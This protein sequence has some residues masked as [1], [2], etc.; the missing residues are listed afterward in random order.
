MSFPVRPIAFVLTST[1][2]GTMIV[3]RNDYCELQQGQRFG[4]GH[5]LLRRSFYEA[6]EIGLALAMLSC[7]QL[8]R[9]D[10]VVALDGGANIGVH[11]VE[12]ARHM[13]G[14]GEV[15]SFEAQEAIFYALAGNLAINN[16]FNAHARLSAL[17]AACGNIMIPVPNYYAPA[18]FGS[19]ELRDGISSE[20]IGQN[21]SYKE[22]DCVSVPIVTIDSLGLKR[23]DFLKID[24]EGMEV[25][26]LEGA[27]AALAA[28]HPVIMAEVIKTDSAK[29]LEILKEFGYEVFN[30]GM[31]VLA[32]GA[33][34]PVL[35]HIEKTDTGIFV[36][37]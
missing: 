21:I 30:L 17:G 6:D 27:R 14:W 12:W 5:Q 33:D 37:L 22:E 29:M 4:V 11:S 10:G 13:F 23:L 2:H 20:F 26:V 8:H 3:N 28:Y 19:L 9:G 24:V 7:V 25:E 34:D 36:T 1:N 18:S 35:K 16:C 15:Y 32:V 31:N